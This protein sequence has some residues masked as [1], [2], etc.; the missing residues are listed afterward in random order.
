MSHAATDVALVSTFSM[1]AASAP[2]PG[3]AMQW[4]NVIAAAVV[5]VERLVSLFRG[6]AKRTKEV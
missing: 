6:R 3:D 5:V 1:L 4:V 2:N